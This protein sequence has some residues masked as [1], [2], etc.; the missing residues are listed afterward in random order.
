MTGY[1]RLSLGAAVDVIFEIQFTWEGNIDYYH[2][3]G[4][5][6]G[7]ELKRRGCRRWRAT[8]RTTASSTAATTC[9][10]AASWDRPG[11]RYRRTGTA[12]TSP[13]ST[14]T[15]CGDWHFCH[16]PGSSG[17]VAACGVGASI[18]GAAI[19]RRTDIPV[20]SHP[21]WVN[22]SPDCDNLRRFGKL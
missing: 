21:S 16:V 15:T 17:A 18:G 2:K 3:K 13:T 22:L 6:F 14:A 20:A 5:K 19:L 4:E 7:V 11:H 9:F 8:S 12:N 1:A 10:G